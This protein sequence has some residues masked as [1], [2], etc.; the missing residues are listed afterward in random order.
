MQH[1]QAR[2]PRIDG[3]WTP[4]LAVTKIKVLEAGVRQHDVVEQVGG[5][6]TGFECHCLQ[7]GGESSDKIYE[8][9]S[10][11]AKHSS[12]NLKTYY[13]GR[14]EQRQE[15]RGGGEL[16]HLTPQLYLQPR[17]VWHNGFRRGKE[18]TNTTRS[19]LD[20][21]EQVCPRATGPILG[22]QC[23]GMECLARNADAI[24]GAFFMSR[25]LVVFAKFIDDLVDEL[26]W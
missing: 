15:I 21:L 8:I 17:G 26:L 7:R 14:V 20:L 9:I 12:R 23:A 4:N 3:V 24:V 25:I 5:E 19:N 22:N 16:K 13:R 11:R 2:R 1:A 6:C 10:P 18:Q